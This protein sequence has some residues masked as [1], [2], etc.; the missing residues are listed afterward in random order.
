MLP[1]LNFYI[2]YLQCYLNIYLVS[3]TP[4][5]L[6]LTPES[7]LPPSLL[8]GTDFGLGADILLDSVEIQTFNSTAPPLC[9]VQ[10]TLYPAGQGRGRLIFKLVSVNN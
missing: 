9:D 6:G 4:A 1:D 10:L 7:L 5:D 2:L 8:P 3:R